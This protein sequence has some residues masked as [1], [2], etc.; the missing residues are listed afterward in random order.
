VCRKLVEYTSQD[1]VLCTL[2]TFWKQDYQEYTS[3]QTGLKS[4]KNLQQGNY[5]K[6]YE[7]HLFLGVGAVCSDD[8][9]YICNISWKTCII[10]HYH[11]S[12]Q[13]GTILQKRKRLIV[14]SNMCPNIFITLGYDF[15]IINTVNVG[16]C[17]NAELY[18]SFSWCWYLHST[19]IQYFDV[20]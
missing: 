6:F 8:L 1:N 3:R 4:C 17:G 11:T 7:S 14:C 20:S 19:Y 9:Y 16:R 13:L 18:K 15:R 5:L 2:C 10:Q 12:R